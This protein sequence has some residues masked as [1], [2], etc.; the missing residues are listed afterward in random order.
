MSPSPAICCSYLLSQHMVLEGG[1]GRVEEVDYSLPT[2]HL[3]GSKVLQN[4]I[5]AMTKSH[6]PNPLCLTLTDAMHLTKRL[7][8]LIDVV[9]D[10]DDDV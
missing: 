9:C 5:E 8:D 7:H 6:D 2:Y 1:K 4:L 3:L 10:A